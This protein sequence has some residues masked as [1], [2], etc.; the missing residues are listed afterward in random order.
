M[1]NHRGCTKEEVP[2]L[3]NCPAG[4]Y[5]SIRTRPVP[6]VHAT[7]IISTRPSPSDR[8]I[9]THIS[10][11]IPTNHPHQ[12]SAAAATSL[13]LMSTTVIASLITAITPALL[14]RPPI[15]SLSLA[16]ALALFV[17]F[18]PSQEAARHPRQAACSCSTA[19]TAALFP[20]SQQR[21]SEASKSAATAAAAT[22][23]LF[24]AS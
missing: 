16:L 22:V 17:L 1:M 10:G 23:A 19:A 6:A 4:R 11:Q 24:P 15:L 3:G 9:K 7:R 20:A 13:L 14:L 5:Q 21:P 2:V 18:P 12:S 8:R